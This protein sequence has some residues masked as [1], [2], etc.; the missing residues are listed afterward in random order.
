MLYIEHVA[1]NVPEPI[2]M[3]DWY[4]THLGL[5]ILGGADAPVPV[6]FIGCPQTGKVVLELYENSKVTVENFAEMS[7]V[8]FHLA[9]ATDNVELEYSKILKV[10]ATPLAPVETLANGSVVAFF[11]DPWGIPV[12][13]ICR[14][15]PLI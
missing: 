8:S 14:P 12:Q 9:F 3:A 6:R 15:T 7:Q 13:F 10:G 2:A 1:L 11:R 4:C 5:K